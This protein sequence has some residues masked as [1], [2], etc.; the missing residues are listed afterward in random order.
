MFVYNM[1]LALVYIPY[2]KMAT[3]G[4]RSLEV[5]AEVEALSTNSHI[6]GEDTGEFI[7]STASDR[8]KLDRF[9]GLFRRRKKAKDEGEEKESVA[10]NRP[11]GEM[12]V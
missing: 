10:K 8:S 5:S 4:G 1:S 7:A 9:G 11:Y 12:G 6:E 3:P 2:G